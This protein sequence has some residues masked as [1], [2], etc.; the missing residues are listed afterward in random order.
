[1]AT[2]SGQKFIPSTLDT[3][4]LN[5]T[6][7]DYRNRN[8]DNVYNENVLLNVLNS[9]CKETING[10]GSIVEPLIEKEQNNG[11]FY[12]GDD[13][14][15][16]SQ[17]NTQTLAEYE[18]QNCYEPIAINRDEERAN[19]GD[20][21][22]ILN[23]MSV[24]MNAAEKAIAKR[25]EQALSQPITTSDINDL[26]TILGTGA[27]GKITGTTDTFWQSTVTTS[28]AFASQGLSDMSTACYAVSSSA[29][30]DTPNF[31]IT[32][33]TIYKKYEDTR[34][35]LE[36]ISSG[37][38]AANAGFK[39]LTFKGEPIVYGNFI[40]SGLLFMLNLNYVKFYVDSATDMII[41]D[42]KEPVNQ[43]AKVA[44]ILWRG[45]L[46]TNNRRRLAKLQSIS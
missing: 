4:V 6:L 42:F 2:L 9:R 15:G 8:T 36:R 10:G 25:V 32:T 21:H 12:Q 18:W 31:I 14:L 5:T 37:A 33:K 23:L 1:M 7:A 13:V 46:G 24:K 30:Q 20:E 26:E 44:F 40:R 34:L 22:K 3:A 17:D 35:P 27:L 11:G 29:N 41:T 38:L 43:T 28:G 19:S 16:T 39:S 45:Q